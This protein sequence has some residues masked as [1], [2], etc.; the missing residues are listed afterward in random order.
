MFTSLVFTPEVSLLRMISELVL[1]IP[2]R[3]ETR[4]ECFVGCFDLFQYQKK[5][6]KMQ[7]TDSSWLL[8]VLIHIP[9][10]VFSNLKFIP[11]FRLHSKSQSTWARGSPFLG[12]DMGLVG[13]RSWC[14]LWKQD[15]ASM[16]CSG[17][18]KLEAFT[19]STSQLY[20]QSARDKGTT[21]RPWCCVIPV[22]LNGN[23]SSSSELESYPYWQCISSHI[24]G[25]DIMLQTCSSSYCQIPAKERVGF[26]LNVR[27]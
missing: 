23:N 10:S 4:S 13:A 27:C 24:C 19:T 8:C 12:I 1:Q 15:L 2:S 14:F 16:Q 7:S 25:A 5:L 20:K 18:W 11:S 9:F 17:S 22:E 21:P 6:C 26:F 3:P